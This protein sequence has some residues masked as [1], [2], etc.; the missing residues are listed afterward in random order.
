MINESCK[1]SNKNPYSKIILAPEKMKDVFEF[2]DCSY[3][4]RNELNL[5]WRKIH[6][7]RY[8]IETACIVGTRVCNSLPCN[9]KESKSHNY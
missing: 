5:N 8:D 2:V 3:S 6:S 1:I 4:L 9:I 7:V